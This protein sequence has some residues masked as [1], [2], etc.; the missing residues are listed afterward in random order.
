MII[1][2]TARFNW[3]KC[4]ILNPNQPNISDMYFGLLKTVTIFSVRF[5]IFMNWDNQFQMLHPCFMVLVTLLVQISCDKHL[6][7][8]QKERWELGNLNIPFQSLMKN[9]S[10]LKS[11]VSCLV[12][13]IK[14]V[15]N[16][17]YCRMNKFH[18]IADYDK[19][20]HRIET[21]DQ[22]QKMI[23]AP[24]QTSRNEEVAGY[25]ASAHFNWVFVRNIYQHE[26]VSQTYVTS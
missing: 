2:C 18:H 25:W 14:H 1:V 3:Y 23:L 24:M 7:S 19:Q 12:H 26:Q 9:D 20:Y 11:Y 17:S 6:F 16:F 10:K 4:R 5:C 21:D 15:H 22:S 13:S 8:G